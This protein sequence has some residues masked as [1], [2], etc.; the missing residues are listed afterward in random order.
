[1]LGRYQHSRSEAYFAVIVLMFCRCFASAFVAVFCQSFASAFA[2]VLQ[3]IFGCLLRMYCSGSQQE[4]VADI[5]EIRPIR[6]YP[7][8]NRLII[9]Q[10]VDIY[11]R[12]NPIN[13]CKNCPE[14]LKNTQNGPD[15]L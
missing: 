8:I 5:P 4:T 6:H 10:N 7:H 1:M 2:A 14:T 9:S 3:V 11:N 12:D 13:I 15:S